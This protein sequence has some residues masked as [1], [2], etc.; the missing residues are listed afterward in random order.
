[1]EKKCCELRY[2]L[3]VSCWLRFCCWGD[4]WGW[5]RT[6]AMGCWLGRLDLRSA[7]GGL[8]VFLKVFGIVLL[9][10]WLKD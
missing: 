1:M 4:C 6:V 7:E 10:S 3:C 9:K 5:L 2:F 8:C